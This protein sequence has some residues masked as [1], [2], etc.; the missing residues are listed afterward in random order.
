MRAV[1]VAYGRALAAQFHP[2]MLFLS[3]VPFLLS[4]VLWGV[5]LYFGL[6]PAID[7]LQALFTE[8]G[9]F[10][11]AGDTLAGIGLGTLK[12][13][14][15]PLL[16]MMLLLPLMI[17]TALVFMGVAA[18]PAIVHHV[19]TRQYPQLVRKK[20]G[21]LAGGALIALAT[22]A[23]FVLLFVAT[24]PLY[25]VPPLAV[26]VHVIL[27]GWLTYRVVTYDALA[28]HASD[29]ERKTIMQ[30]HKRPLLAIGMISGAAGAIPGLVWVGGAVLS[31]VLF[32]FLAAASIWLYVVVFIFTGL[33][34]EYYC[35]QA[36]AE[37]RAARGEQA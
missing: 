24:L 23:V 9:W 7:A 21:S 34:F 19:G 5:V 27:W 14:L 1:G 25:A 36:L 18:M 2:R 3:A 32:P 28:D 6:Q 13:V 26:A 22:F 20:G 15:V 29:E 11:T 10:R 30:L 37:L 33:W 8:Y 17:L 35:L 31:F 4:L 12:A 16:A